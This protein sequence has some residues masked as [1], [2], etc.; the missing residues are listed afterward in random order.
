M[1]GLIIC[2]ALLANTVAF[3]G[4]DTGVDID[5]RTLAVSF[6]SGRVRWRL[7]ALDVLP[8]P[9]YERFG[10]VELGKEEVLAQNLA[11]LPFEPEDEPRF[12]LSFTVGW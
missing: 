2:L 5:A 10:G 4:D 11:T 6:G 7:E 8:L 9:E 1:R 3:A 12:F